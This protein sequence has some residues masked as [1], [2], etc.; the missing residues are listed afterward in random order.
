VL[1]GEAVVSALL[2]AGVWR[3]PHSVRIFQSFNTTF[4]SYWPVT[5]RLSRTATRIDRNLLGLDAECQ[6]LKSR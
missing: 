6:P 4:Y 1:P 5:V 2:D 3:S